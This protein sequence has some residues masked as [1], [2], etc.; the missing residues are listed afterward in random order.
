MAYSRKYE[1]SA[2]AVVVDP[3]GRRILMVRSRVGRKGWGFP[4]GHILPTEGPLDAAKREV[5]EETGLPQRH[6]SPLGSL[7]TVRQV[8]RYPRAEE[9]VERE[10]HFFLFVSSSQVIQDTPTD[11]HH[12]R[13]SWVLWTT[14]RRISPRY[15]YV[16]HL[17]KEA[18]R[19]FVRPASKE[20][21]VAK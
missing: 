11:E 18:R 3:S 8:I 13:A 12:D 4:K 6:L 19:L 10:T 16:P 20:E 17:A 5:E 15:R 14:L 1:F 9:I 7:R 21:Q 2:G